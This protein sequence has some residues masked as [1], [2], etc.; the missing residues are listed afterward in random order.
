MKK[1]LA[2]QIDSDF[3][4]EKVDV[5]ISSSSFEDRCF[6]IPKI[7]IK[8]DLKK[9]IIFS[10]R[11]EGEIVNKNANKL[12]NLDKEKSKKVE[13]NSNDPVSIYFQISKTVNEILSNFTKPHIVVD[14]TTFTHESL[15]IL[16][17]YI[18]LKFDGFR[19]VTCLY[20]GAKEYSFNVKDDNDKWLSKGII[21]IRTILGYPGLTDFT[22]KNH[23]VILFGFEFN[24]T[25]QIINEYE[26]DFIS[27]GFAN[28]D[29]SIQ[30]NHQKI[31]YERHCK[32]VSEYSNINEFN[33]SCVNPYDAKRQLLEYINKPQFK[34]LNTV[35]APLNNKLSTIGAGLAA[36]ENEKIQL[37]YAKPAIYNTYGYSIPNSDIY[38]FDLKF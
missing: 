17:K 25:R 7:F 26:Y 12:V 21:D 36:I 3:N 4:N 32:I 14:V 35:I 23:L 31:N 37:A 1:L 33:F 8:L 29:S 34:N 19:K 30:T 18:Q 9:R 28:I 6:I 5:I 38:T 27:I 2:S 20:V 22:E 13:F 24:R 15:L 16:L 11:N 10:N